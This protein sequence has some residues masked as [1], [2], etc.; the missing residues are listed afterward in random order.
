M[1]TITKIV[2]PLIPTLGKPGM[3]TMRAIDVRDILIAIRES[4][5]A[6]R[7]VRV[8]SDQGFVPHS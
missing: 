4:R 7:R 8:Y 2:K 1:T 6:N 3:K 5:M